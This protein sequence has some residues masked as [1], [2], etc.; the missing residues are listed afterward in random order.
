VRLRSANL[1]SAGSDAVSSAGA[2]AGAS[3]E[4]IK[5]CF[6]LLMQLVH[7]D[8]QGEKKRWPD[9]CAAQANWA[10]AMLRDQE[11]RRTFEEEA[12]A[13][14]RSLV[15]SIAHR[16]WPRRL[17]WPTVSWPKKF[18][19]G[20]RPFAGAGMPECLTADGGRVTHGTIRG[21]PPSL[22]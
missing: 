22:R 1:L 15:R 14:L 20:E 2:R 7:P 12:D 21:P 6:R 8:R 5:E 16:R 3:L 17:R 13:E 4:A 19:K 10:Y 11:T 18:G 9:A